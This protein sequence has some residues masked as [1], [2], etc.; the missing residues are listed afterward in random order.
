MC[1]HT[2]PYAPP[3]SGDVGGMNVVVRHTCDAL[4]RAGHDVEVVTRWSDPASAREETID[5]VAIRRLA[6]GPARS[7]PKG[8]HEGLMVDFGRALGELEPRDLLHSHHWFSGMAALPVARAW[9]VPHVQSFHSI[10]APERTALSEGERPE[11]PG[12]LDGEAYLAQHSDAVLA[13]SR[14]EALTA[15]ERLGAPPQ[16]LTVVYPGVDP[17]LFHPADTRPA[18]R[19]SVLIAARLEPLKGVDLAIRALALIPP[20][21]R[22]VLRVAGGAT[23][24]PGFGR[25]LLALA[26]ELG[27][28]GDVELL[29]PQSRTAL[30]GL[31]RAATLVLVPSHSETYGL[32]ALEAAASGVPV[33]ASATGGLVEAVRDGET[34]LLVPGREPAD[35]AAAIGRVTGDPALAAHLGAAGRSMAQNR[36]WDAVG[37]VVAHAYAAML[38]SATVVG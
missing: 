22:P 14:A 20:A 2:D 38:P 31:M 8:E 1:L 33:V 30:A 13:V 3:G 12:R 27:A 11:S 10:A 29:G 26:D 32:V 37:D 7:L 23:A 36:G 5:G 28:A 24:D 21:A 17:V 25:S 4:A 19:P 16:R 35:W 6:V 15:L 34:G 9:G 18:G